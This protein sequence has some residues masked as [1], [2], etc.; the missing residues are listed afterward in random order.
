MEII[1][2][3][4][5]RAE[6]PAGHGDRNKLLDRDV[7]K[8]IGAL[9]TISRVTLECDWQAPEALATAL[10]AVNSVSNSPA[11][12]WGPDPL[13][14]LVDRACAFL[15]ATGRED[16][17]LVKAMTSGYARRAGADLAKHYAIW[18]RLRTLTHK[19]EAFGRIDEDEILHVAKR[20]IFDTDAKGRPTAYRIPSD[21]H[22]WSVHPVFIGDGK[23]RLYLS[24]SSGLVHQVTFSCSF[25]D[26]ETFEPRVKTQFPSENDLDKALRLPLL[27]AA[28]AAS[29]FATFHLLHV[30]HD[31]PGHGNAISAIVASL[32]ERCANRVA[33]F[34]GLLA[35]DLIG[36][37]RPSAPG[38]APTAARKRR[39]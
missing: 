9:S 24:G 5:A 39:L 36:S 20:T 21:L 29:S 1:R 27:G 23:D 38:G 28:E 37:A 12:D 16:H 25:Y 2:A 11:W 7:D 14:A 26:L 8:L 10:I 3:L 6:H 22:G 34:I 4:P 30:L 15:C 32:R 18:S 13:S 31:L 33:D 17:P 35:D 19:D